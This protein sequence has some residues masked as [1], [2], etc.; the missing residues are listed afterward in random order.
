[1]SVLIEA[2]ISCAR[3]GVKP[4]ISRRAEE[5]PEYGR[6]MGLQGLRYVASWVTADLRRCDQVMECDDPALLAQ[7]TARWE[8]LVE[9]EIVPV[10]TSAEAAAV[11]ADCKEEDSCQLYAEI[12]LSDGG[13]WILTEL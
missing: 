8:D 2:V 13:L 11:P 9:F 7:W 10:V 3:Q 6:W 1:M 12:P 4:P 5:Y